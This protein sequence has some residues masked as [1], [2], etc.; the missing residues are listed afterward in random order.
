MLAYNRI[1][2][3]C[4]MSDVDHL[5]CFRNFI[6]MDKKME[7][8]KVT[9]RNQVSATD[10]VVDTIKNRLQKGELHVG[11]KLPSESEL[12]E[13]LGVSRSSVREGIKV[14]SSYGLLEIRR[15][16]GTYVTD[17]FIDEIL[18]TLGFIPKGINLDYL[19]VVRRILECGC[20]GIIYNKLTDEQLDKLEGLAK[21]LT[22]G[23]DRERN[24]ACDSEFHNF[25]F[26]CSDNPILTSI[27]RM[28]SQ[29]VGYI[30]HN[31]NGY[32]EIVSA[33]R[34]AHMS[35]VDALRK[36]DYEACINSMGNHLFTVENFASKY[37]QNEQ[38]VRT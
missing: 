38:E 31:L 3:R 25:L 5:M 37:L 17:R 7:N 27:Y 23:G 36:K 35:I 28:I 8:L 22:P 29:M 6:I 13:E 26:Q 12:C 4:L 2:I 30:I 11:D 18:S 32:D 1:H 20:M 33:A 9:K 21:E 24:I 16:Q 14:L 34:S 15:G 19:L 10:F